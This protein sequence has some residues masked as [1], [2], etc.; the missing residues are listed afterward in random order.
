[1]ALR[2]VWTGRERFEVLLL[3][4]FDTSTLR[5]WIYF[6]PEGD[7]LV[8][9]IP[10]GDCP[11]IELVHQTV[12]VLLRRGLV[13][14][15][16]FERLYAE[17]PARREEIAQ[18]LRS[19]M[20]ERPVDSPWMSWTPAFGDLRLRQLAEQLA[21]T[22]RERERRLAFNAEVSDLDAEIVAI[23]RT[24]REGPHLNPGDCLL[25]GR[26]R[27]LERVGAGG[28]SV[29]WRAVDREE[30]ELVA[31]KVLH[32]QWC[33]D[34]ER[35][36][37][38][39]RGA[40]SMSRLEHENITLVRRGVTEDGGYLFYVME[41][42]QGTD[43]ERAILAENTVVGAARV[44]VEIALGV[45]RGLAHAHTHGLVHRDIK[46]S[47]VLLTERFF[48][49]LTDF[50]LVWGPNTTGGTG[51]GQGMGTYVY[52]APEALAG[53]SRADARA[54]VYSLG[55]TL[56]FLFRGTKLEL[57]APYHRHAMI[58]ELGCHPALK[59]ILRRAVEFDPVQR[60]SSA[61]E[62]LAGLEELA[63]RYGYEDL[64]VHQ[65]PPE[66]PATAARPG[67]ARRALLALGRGA[68]SIDRHWILSLIVAPAVAVLL[69]RLIA[70]PIQNGALAPGLA[71]MPAVLVGF[72]GIFG[73]GLV[74][75]FGD[76]IILVDNLFIRGFRGFVSAIMLLILFSV[77]LNSPPIRGL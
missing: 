56:V 44:A 66:R 62:V 31:L 59:T 19:W 2:Q 63:G 34:P 29:V 77:V 52:G 65:R 27:L 46:P 39:A 4:L 57:D 25:K 36:E 5:R 6:G 22:Y 16:L 74:W 47:N 15:D 28:F 17:F 37:R 23:R 53:T 13:D 61:S 24:L 1:M 7:L 40:R 43:L 64:L 30:Q 32:S 35:R 26:Y 12:S 72:A 11:L 3:D 54:D 48:P 21:E 8:T 69:V 70:G 68:R 67:P 10:S 60:F 9:L 42:M 71:F 49:K 45:C 38:F 14:V 55:M 75:F 73:G 33:L 18:H 76:N 50:D 20:C 41:W 51:L 58:D